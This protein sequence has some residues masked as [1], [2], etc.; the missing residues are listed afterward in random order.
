MDSTTYRWIQSLA[1]REIF[2]SS[3]KFMHNNG[4]IRYQDVLREPI[5]FPY[6]TDRNSPEARL[7]R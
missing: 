3:A 4:M 1:S 5:G 7:V 6:A 2:Q